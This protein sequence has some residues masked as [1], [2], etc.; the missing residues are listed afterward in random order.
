M[1]TETRD[2]LKGA[3]TEAALGILKEAPAYLLA[4]F[5]VFC[6]FLTQFRVSLFSPFIDAV[7]VSLPPPQALGEACTD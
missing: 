1:L 5:F 6:S 4:S 3:K 7:H 2:L